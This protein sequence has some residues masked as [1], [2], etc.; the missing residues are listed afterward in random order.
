[1][2]VLCQSDDFGLVPPE[3]ATVPSAVN[4][5][6]RIGDLGSPGVESE[7]GRHFFRLTAPV[8]Q[9]VSSFEP[10]RSATDRADPLLRWLVSLTVQPADS[11]TA[12]FL[13]AA[14]SPIN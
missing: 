1:M 11:A 14:S 9:P 5:P 10:M 8:R 3:L 7:K 2:L 4:R 6:C 13:D 12:A